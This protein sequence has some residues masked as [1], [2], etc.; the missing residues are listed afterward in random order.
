MCSVILKLPA[1][2]SHDR[3][4]ASPLSA[5]HCYFRHTVHYDCIYALFRCPSKRYDT[6]RY[7]LLLRTPS[8]RR[9]SDHAHEARSQPDLARRHA[10]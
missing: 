7:V 2:H 8:M 4:A 6:I 1:V 10:P 3:P 9:L 5:L